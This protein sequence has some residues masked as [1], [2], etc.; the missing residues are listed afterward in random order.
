MARLGASEFAEVRAVLKQESFLI[1]PV[2][3]ES[4][5]IEFAAV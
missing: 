4:I 1:P 5:Y 3:D 2:S